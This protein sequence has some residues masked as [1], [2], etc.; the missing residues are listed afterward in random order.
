MNW[1]NG[2]KLKTASFYFTYHTPCALSP[3]LGLIDVLS[4]V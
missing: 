3:L 4:G 1:S 2:K